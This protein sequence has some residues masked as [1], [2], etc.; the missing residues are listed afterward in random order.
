MK[1]RNIFQ[2]LNEYLA[3]SA[4]KRIN[5]EINRLSDELVVEAKK[6]YLTANNKPM[7]EINQVEE[8]AY[9]PYLK[10]LILQD[11][12]QAIHS[13]NRLIQST[14]KTAAEGQLIDAEYVYQVSDTERQQINDLINSIEK[15]GNVSPF[16]IQAVYTL[17]IE[18]RP[19]S[20]HEY[21][22]DT[23]AK[24]RN[25]ITLLKQECH[26]YLAH[27]E[28]T[29]SK[30]ARKMPSEVVHHYQEKDSPTKINIQKLITD[31]ADGCS[32][33]WPTDAS[34]KN[35]HS[36][37]LY[38]GLYAALDKYTIVNNMLN[39]LD[40]SNMQSGVKLAQF[41]KCLSENKSKLSEHRDSAAMKFF[42]KILHILSGGIVSKLT[43]DT[44]Q[45]WKSHGEV[46]SDK[47]ENIESAKFKP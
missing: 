34:F 29:I 24:N 32:F 7:T 40:K 4:D 13:P 17:V 6:Q 45:Y 18:R 43:K 1:R 26:K 14:E 47:A 39:G 22:Q 12:K 20:A 42:K 9:M 11:A 2:I 46:F 3:N 16:G 21:I 5:N 37:K 15:K 31:K 10:Q 38:P 23:D 44:F 8:D 33:I 25:K 28:S 41:E 27:L 36:N 19:N 30:L 35:I